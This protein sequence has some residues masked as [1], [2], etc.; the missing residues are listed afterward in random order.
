MGKSNNTEVMTMDR[1]EKSNSLVST[2]GTIEDL[3]LSGSKRQQLQT[4]VE[5]F[6]ELQTELCNEVADKETLTEEIKRVQLA[7]KN[8]PAIQKLKNLK[9]EMRTKSANISEISSRRA[10]ALGLCEKQGLNL[11]K[12]LKIALVNSE[13]E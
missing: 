5:Y 1:I 7:I 8:S 6:T 4:A 10:G 12:H 2:N 13:G 3:N 9:K 11:K